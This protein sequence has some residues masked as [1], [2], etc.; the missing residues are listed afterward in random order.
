MRE[1]GGATTMMVRPSIVTA[2]T[3][4]PGS[5]TACPAAR[6]VQHG[7]Q[8]DRGRAR[9]S[10][11][12]RPWPGDGGH[13][14]HGAL[15]SQPSRHWHPSRLGPREQ[16]DSNCSFGPTVNTAGSGPIRSWPAGC[17]R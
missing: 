5:G 1:C 4:K 7:D 8:V 2:C 17:R 12:I 14:K 16:I 10:R 6:A 13:D 11:R 15:E 9:W 3:A